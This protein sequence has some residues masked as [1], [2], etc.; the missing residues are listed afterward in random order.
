MKK[1]SYAIRNEQIEEYYE[2]EY[3]YLYLCVYMLWIWF[4]GAS[5]LER[6]K[7]IVFKDV[8]ND[9]LYGVDNSV[10]VFN[11]YFGFPLQLH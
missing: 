1:L 7:L 5:I 11:M 2:M 4:I 10:P 9:T 6:K 8:V 3:I